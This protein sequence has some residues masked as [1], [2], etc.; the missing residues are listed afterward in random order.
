MHI[1]VTAGKTR[2]LMGG[3][4]RVAASLLQMGIHIALELNAFDHV[5]TLVTS[6]SGSMRNNHRIHVIPYR[7]YDD[8]ARIMEKEVRSGAYDAVVHAAVVSDYRPSGKVFTLFED[9]PTESPDGRLVIK[10]VVVPGKKLPEG[11]EVLYAEMVE[12]DSLIDQIRTAWKFDGYVVKSKFVTGKSDGELIE[13]SRKSRERSNA[14][15]IIAY[16][17]MREV[18]IGFVI[19]SDG[20]ASMITCDMIP[21]TIMHKM[22]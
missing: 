16:D 1:L 21:Q 6:D 8:L 9:T 13:L 11:H 22:G 10:P 14:N 18:P 17:L 2:T 19:G 7:S 4:S 5:V 15:L 12:T 3:D 20:R